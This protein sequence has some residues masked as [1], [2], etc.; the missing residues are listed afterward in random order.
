MTEFSGIDSLSAGDILLY[1]TKSLMG[2]AIRL[3]DGTEVSHA[4]IFLGDEVAEALAREGLVQRPVAESIN[5]ESEWVA[6]MRVR[7][8]PGPMT[9]VLAV[10]RKYLDQGNRYGYGQI[11]LL[12]GICLTRK[13]DW[14]NWLLRRIG[15]TVFDKS[16]ALLEKFRK[17]G[18][19]PMICSEFVFRTYDE[20]QPEPDD[21]YSLAIL[22][23]TAGEPRR[24]F[25]RFRQEWTAARRRDRAGGSND[26]S[27]QPSGT[28]AGSRRNTRGIACS[29]R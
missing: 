21:P 3:L 5:D 23:Q 24:W 15:R 18:K 13:V 17:E 8:V 14:D 12:A 22:S 19:E 26:S 1:R 7:P 6:V 10:A 29:S 20:A 28:L 25:S 16:T 27:R 2:R 11:L 4:A 9:P